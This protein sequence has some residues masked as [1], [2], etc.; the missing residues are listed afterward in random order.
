MKIL[1]YAYS[2]YPSASEVV[3]EGYYQFT[4][5]YGNSKDET[6]LSVSYTR[7]TLSK[8]NFRGVQ[9]ETIWEIADVQTLTNPESHF[10]DK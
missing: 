8:I 10:T 1:Q 6:I 9:P 2:T 3:V 5:A 7:A 4:D